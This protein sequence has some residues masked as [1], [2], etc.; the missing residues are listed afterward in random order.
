[1]KQKIAIA[2]DHKGVELKSNIIKYLTS[3]KYKVLD[4]GPD[5]A[6]ESV[7]Y[8]DYAKKVCESIVDKESDIGILVCGTGIGMS[9]AA[10]RRSGIRAALCTNVFMAERSRAHNDANILVIGSRISTE[11]D[12]INMLKTFLKTSFEGGRHARRL[13]KIS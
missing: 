1:M 5:D 4:L 11:E 9:I 2:T 7:D 6:V 10:N 8:P 12:S 13:A 3:Q